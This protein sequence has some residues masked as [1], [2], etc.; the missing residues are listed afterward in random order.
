MIPNL[1]SE[2]LKLRPF[3]PEDA[4]R[5]QKLA[6][7][8]IIAEMTENIPHPYQDGMAEAWIDEHE[9]WYQNRVAAVFAMVIRQTDELI[10]AISFTQ[11]EEQ[12]GNLGYWV[13]LPYWG[14][15]YCT[16]ASGLLL[17]FGFNQ[18][19]LSQI[20]ARHLA[21]NPASGRVI[22]KNGFH[23]LRDEVVA[24]RNVK[25]YELKKLQW[26]SLHKTQ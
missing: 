18:F 17:E 14:N 19:G 20:Y 4:A 26:Q 16:E 9:S 24:G 5:V 11:I 12:T 22:T 10:G 1:Q 15:G 13:G 3:K 2:R 6:G 21:K 7:E 23:Y 8:K 25:H